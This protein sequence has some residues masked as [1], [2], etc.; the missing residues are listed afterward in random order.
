MCRRQVIASADLSGTDP[1][2]RRRDDPGRLE[3]HGPISIGGDGLSGSRPFGPTPDRPR[4]Q[5]TG[6]ARRGRSRRGRQLSASP[7]GRAAVLSTT[8]EPRDAI[9]A[10]TSC[11][12]PRRPSSKCVGFRW[13]FEGLTVM[14]RT[15]TPKHNWTVRG[16][17]R[18]TPYDD[19]SHGTVHEQQYWIGHSDPA[20]FCI[21][22]D[23]GIRKKQHGTGSE[24]RPQLSK[25]SK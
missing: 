2:D 20:A 6:R 25:G 21:R 18:Q 12:R 14:T 4:I 24:D 16:W 7:I 19:K 13:W 5:K 1:I 11:R 17:Y 23:C 22:F 9:T 10:P 3:I 15:G 8:R